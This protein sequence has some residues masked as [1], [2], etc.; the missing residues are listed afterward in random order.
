MYT[1]T[2]HTKNACDQGKQ[3]VNVLKALAGT[4]WGQ[5]KEMIVTAYKSIVRSKLEYAAPIWTPAISETNWKRL[6]TV[7]NAALRIATGCHRMADSDHLHHETEVIPIRAHCGLL[8]KQYLLIWTPTP[9]ANTLI[10]HL[11]SDI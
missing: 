1:F 5:Q 11:Q 2:P 3:R 8:T 9:A 10:A 4:D 7:E 6:E